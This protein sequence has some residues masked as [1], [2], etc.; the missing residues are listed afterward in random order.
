MTEIMAMHRT[1]LFRQNYEEDFPFIFRFPHGKNPDYPWKIVFNT[2]EGTNK[3][4][5]SFTA[6]FDGEH[7]TNCYPV[8]NEPGT[9]LVEFKDHRLPPGRLCFRL[10][11]TVPNALFESGEQK[12]VLPQ[13][14]DWELWSGKTDGEAPAATTIVLERL[15]QGIG[16]PSGGN[17]GQILVK[18]SGADYDMAWKD[19]PAGVSPLH[20]GSYLQFPTVGDPEKLYID[21]TTNKSYRWDETQL[22]Y[23]CIGVGI[24]HDDEIILDSNI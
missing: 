11:R 13:L 2:Y 1:A 12:K 4:R 5:V 19:M 23:K 20:F 10:L 18:Q 16:I 8:D 17:A 7:Y 6:S 22:C 21:S 9:I 14:T 15:L 3:S 24:D